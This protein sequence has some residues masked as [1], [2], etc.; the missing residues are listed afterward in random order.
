M[1]NSFVVAVF[2]LWSTNTFDTPTSP[3]ADEVVRTTVLSQTH[4]YTIP[5]FQTVTN[6][7][8]VVTNSEQF[9]LIWVKLPPVPVTKTN[10]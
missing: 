4:I 2:V 3:K 1:T 5:G 9:S 10:R 7:V 8:P 6:H